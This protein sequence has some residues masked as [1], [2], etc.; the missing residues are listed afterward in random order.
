MTD[1]PLFVPVIEGTTRRGRMS[2]HAA[3]LMVEEIGKRPGVETE[4]IDIAELP[5]PVDDAGRGIRTRAS[6]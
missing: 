4:L 1:R 5:M 2:L 6:R 3:R